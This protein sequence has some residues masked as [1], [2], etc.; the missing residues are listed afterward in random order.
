MRGK[1]NLRDWELTKWQREFESYFHLMDSNPRNKF[2]L[3][4]EDL[5]PANVCQILQSMGWVQDNFHAEGWDQFTWYDYKH[6]AYSFGITLYYCGY[7]FEMIL[8]RTDV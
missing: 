7:T 5:S 3:T 8:K 2:D 1:Y 6:Y 4:Q